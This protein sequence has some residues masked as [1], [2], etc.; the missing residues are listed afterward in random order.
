MKRQLMGTFGLA[1]IMSLGG[2]IARADFV[3]TLDDAASGGIE[4]IVADNLGAGVF[5]PGS[6]LTTTHADALG[7]VGVIL[8][9]GPIGDF[10]TNTVTGI[11]KPL[12]GPPGEM[13]LAG[14]HTSNVSGLMTVG[15]TDTGFGSATSFTVRNAFGGVAGGTVVSE[16]GA[17]LDNSHFSFASA[18]GS[19]GPFGPGAFDDES[20]IGP[21]SADPSF[22]LTNSVEI[23]HGGGSSVTSYSMNVS[24]PEPGTALLLIAAVPILLRRR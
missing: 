18:F 5:L 3:L 22:S 8:F 19:L 7:D 9:D 15:L 1:A 17:D 10:L 21:L 4:V 20:S 6:G 23:T 14:V 13:L 2:S 11:S 24:V 16:W 12:L